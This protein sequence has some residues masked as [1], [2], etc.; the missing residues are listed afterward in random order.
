MLCF[1]QR[2]PKWGNPRDGKMALSLHVGWCW[3]AAGCSEWS[4]HRA[5]GLG[6]ARVLVFIDH[7]NYC[8]KSQLNVE[9]R[10]FTEGRRR[11]SGEEGAVCGYPSER[12]VLRVHRGTRVPTSLITTISMSPRHY[13]SR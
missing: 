11:M 6:W 4:V 7:S 9:F 5:D 2:F 8:I 3:D 13:Q 10:G 1:R 12:G